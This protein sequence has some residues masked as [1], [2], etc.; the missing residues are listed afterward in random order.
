MKNLVYY[1]LGLKDEYFS[2]FEKSIKSLDYSNPE[3]IDVLIITNKSFFDKNLFN[4]ERKNTYY[5]FVD[6]FKNGDDVCFSKLNVFDWEGIG[7]YENLLMIDCD[8]LVDTQLSEIFQKCTDKNKLYAPIEDESFENHRR[9]YFSLGNYTDEDIKFFKDNNIHTFNCGT[10]MLKNSP[11]MRNHFSTVNR[12][13]KGYTG[14]YF[15]DQSFMNYYFN[16]SKLVDY[17]VIDSKKNL[18]YA[19]QE[20]IDLIQ[21]T[22]GKIFHFIGN[23]YS[24]LYKVDIMD[25]VYQ[26]IIS[27]KTVEFLGTT[28]D[29]CTM[30]FMSKTD[31]T[32]YVEV[33]RNSEIVY[34]TVLHMVPNQRYWISLTEGFSNKIVKFSEKKNHMYFEIDGI[35][36]KYDEKIKDVDLSI[37]SKI[38]I[39]E[40][41][42]NKESDLDL[43][44]FHFMKTLYRKKNRILDL[45]SNLFRLVNLKKHFIN[46]DVIGT[47]SNLYEI[48]Q[49]KY[50]DLYY[51]DN[52][53]DVLLNCFL[54]TNKLFD[55]IISKNKSVFF[56]SS[57][58]SKL[59][60]LL[61]V[62]GT[63]FVENIETIYLHQNENLFNKGDKKFEYNLLNLY[64]SS[65]EDG[66]ILLEI[67]R[68]N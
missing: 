64:S 1:C 42:N 41:E 20:N 2:I 33:F 62:G 51:F 3:I 29:K 11:E 26:K 23:T 35:R 63:I 18:V 12:M 44:F 53:S 45:D 60:D 58:I 21:D 52:I 25:K 50:P 7:G 16:K 54:Q 5:H 66:K 37:L 55:I 36:K 43:Y 30:Y 6:E 14:D 46:S 68:T 27:Q 8:V 40:I 22:K 56:N 19:V 24:G 61:D 57:V 34:D 10:Y 67:I 65:K 28:E 4:F 48:Q 31:S 39:L 15:S 32:Y 59:L 49:T 13:I 38:Q 9:I 47:S 17:S